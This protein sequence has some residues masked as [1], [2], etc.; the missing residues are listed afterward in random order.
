MYS[1][2][3]SQ[4]DPLHLQFYI[5]WLDNIQSPECCSYSIVEIDYTQNI[6]DE[7]IKMKTQLVE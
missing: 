5:Q 1:T 3:Y 6:N 4:L 2:E 7:E